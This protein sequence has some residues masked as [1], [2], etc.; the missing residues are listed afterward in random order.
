M[1]D[2]DSRVAEFR[3]IARVDDE[4]GTVDLQRLGLFM[5]RPLPEGRPELRFYLWQLSLGV[6]PTE[7]AQWEPVWGAREAQYFGLVRKLFR[8]CS[9]FL[10][11]GF[12]VGSSLEC[13]DV[14]AG[15]H[16]DVLR[17]PRFWR[18][19]KTIVGDEDGPRHSRRLERLIYA[20]SI[21]NARCPYTQ[22]F[23][24]VAAPLYCVAV[25]G[26][27]A[28]GLSDDR[29]EAIAF[30]MLFGVMV[31]GQL[32]RVFTAVGRLRKIERLFT[33]VAEAVALADS[34]FAEFLFQTR[35]VLPVTF[36]F[37]WVSVLFAQSLGVADLLRLWDH[38]FVLGERTVDFAM[39]VAAARVIN[40]R[41]QL[42]ALDFDGVMMELH[43]GGDMDVA[44]VLGI[45]RELW[46][47][48]G[49]LST[50]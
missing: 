23:H 25:T 7:R 37:P 29:A 9:G 12:V 47:R 18:E 42:Y 28:L 4:D 6:L 10:D 21:V 20:F 11:A 13:P 48:F 33:R 17:L 15:I 2:D 40:M 1:S 35:R 44:A 45:A 32:A 8:R 50:G 46:A 49:A 19:I 34:D 5:L 27:R 26:A 41:E 39:F 43:A 30:C 22:G 3:R 38:L 24:E 31:K 36:V 14:L 16:S